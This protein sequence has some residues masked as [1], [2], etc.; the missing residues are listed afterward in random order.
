MLSFQKFG[1]SRSKKPTLVLLHGWG[2]QWKSWFPIIEGLKA[3]FALIVPDLPGFGATPLEQVMTLDAYAHEVEVLLSVFK[4]KRVTLIGHSFGGAVAMKIAAQRPE[5]VER[6]IL[7]DA[8]G[9]RPQRSLLNQAWIAAVKAGN[10]LFSLPGLEH[11]HAKLRKTLYSVGPFKESDYAALNDPRMKQT[12]EQIITEDISDD[13]VRI[14]CPTTL[15]W[16]DQD[17]DAPLW[18][19]ERLR[20]LIPNAE[21]V[22]FEG[23]GH[24]SYLEQSDRFISLVLE[25]VS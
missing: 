3:H 21:L 17:K 10:A 1:V 13:A 6:L 15:V 5:V 9:I 12:F 18:M 25:R 8:S 22:V 14:T 2:G 11:V 4:L 19:G 7:V 23:V 24:F 16:G 20:A